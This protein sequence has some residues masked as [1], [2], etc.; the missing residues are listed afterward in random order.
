MLDTIARLKLADLPT[1]LEDAPRLAQHLGISRLL[2]KRDDQPGPAM[3]GNRARKLEYDFAEI[4]K[5][6]CDVVVT[7]GG[8]Q[9]N[10]A[11]MTAAAARKLGIEATLVLGGRDTSE[12]QGNML[13][14]VL[15]GT[16]IR[17]LKNNDDNDDLTAAMNEWDQKL[18]QESRLSALE[19]PEE[20]M[21]I[22]DWD[23]H[24]TPQGRVTSCMTVVQ[25]GRGSMPQRDL[26]SSP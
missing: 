9:S 11:R 1:P 8:A 18:R 10:H 21:S 5:Q 25:T 22:G 20:Q 24:S 2:M 16:E 19:K 15:L 7:V 12:F 26:A 4:V 23:G 14:D 13:L 17:F 6:G 3:G